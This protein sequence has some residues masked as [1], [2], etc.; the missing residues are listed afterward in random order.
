[1]RSKKE[2]IDKMIKSAGS[3]KPYANIGREQSI[4]TFAISEVLIDIRDILNEMRENQNE[5]L[6]MLYDETMEELLQGCED[7]EDK[8]VEPPELFGD[9]EDFELDDE[10][11]DLYFQ[12][13]FLT[14][15]APLKTEIKP[16]PMSLI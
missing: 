11:D 8:Y 9:L 3:P 4:A 2:I 1:M 14:N 12:G 6:D 5:E 16:S 13:T 15:P 10:L 7:T